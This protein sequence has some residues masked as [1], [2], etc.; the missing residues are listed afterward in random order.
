MFGY[1]RER[2]LSE[3]WT[4]WAETLEESCLSLVAP[5]LLRRG[6]AVQFGRAGHKALWWG[7]GVV[8]GTE[9]AAAQT[10]SSSPCVLCC[11][12]LWN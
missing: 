2:C 8:M 9:P 3:M 7:R 11:F 5:E 1:G 6:L 10:A 12:C 4:I